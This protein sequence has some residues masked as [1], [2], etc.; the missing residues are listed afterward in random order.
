[1]TRDAAMQD[2]AGSSA[3]II[4]VSDR[5]VSKS[6]APRSWNTDSL[7]LRF[8]VD[9]ASATTAG[10]LICPIITIIDR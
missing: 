2:A 8:G 3:A 5:P 10:A 9:V 1:M 7:G 4:P 6:A